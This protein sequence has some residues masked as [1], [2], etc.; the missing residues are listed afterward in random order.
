MLFVISCVFGFQFCWKRK[1]SIPSDWNNGVFCFQLS[2]FKLTMKTKIWKLVNLNVQFSVIGYWKLTRLM[3]SFKFVKLIISYDFYKSYNQI[4]ELKWCLT[5]LKL[6][7]FSGLRL[8]LL[9]FNIQ[10]FKNKMKR[11][12]GLNYWVSKWYTS[13]WFSSDLVIISFVTR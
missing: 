1:K 8:L 7:W 13:N 10:S 2:F 11:L 9:L 4:L 5:G 6:L 3:N 12:K